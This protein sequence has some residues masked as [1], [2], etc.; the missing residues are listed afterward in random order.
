MANEYETQYRLRND[1]KQLFTIKARVTRS[2]KSGLEGAEITAHIEHISGRSFTYVVDFGGEFVE[3][4]ENFT[5]EMFL[6]TAVSIVE[7]QIESKK[8]R[9]TLLQVHCHSGLTQTSP[10]QG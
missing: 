7:A 1:A 6:H 5:P 2:G 4:K 8:Y 9:D 3:T 10:L